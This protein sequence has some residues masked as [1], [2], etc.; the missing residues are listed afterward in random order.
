MGRRDTSASKT[1]LRRALLVGGVPQ[2]YLAEWGITSDLGLVERTLGVRIET[3]A[4]EEFLARREALS[5]AERE[6]AR[7]LAEDLVAG[8]A[9][10]DVEPPE[11]E[12]MLDATR[13]HV[14]LRA[15]MAERGADAVSTICGVIREATGV[16]P[17]VALMLLQEEGVPAACQGDIDAL[18][19]M[20]M[21][22]R[23]TGW[24]SFMGGGFG[25]GG[26][27]LVNHCVLSRRM[28]GADAPLQPYY[29][30]RYHNRLNSP[31]VHTDPP[32]GQ[33]VTVARLT[34]NLEGLLLASGTLVATDDPPDRCRNT[35][36]IDLA[37]PARLLDRVRGHQNH[38]VIALGDHTEAL[39]RAADA[40][41]IPV[42]AV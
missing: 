41:G 19:T 32:T 30:G 2:K 28:A 14:A 15:M 12:A 42:I 16:V 21:L 17:C 22:K 38:V 5:A 26:R 33:P 27:L 4:L 25:E 20:V 35:L 3:V 13:L 9:D 36:V 8:A 37:D 10:A 6:R 23:A 29:L 39:G 18:L 11:G 40:A 1:G 34:R 7:C 31:T 24:I